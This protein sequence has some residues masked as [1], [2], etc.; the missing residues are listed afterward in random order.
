MNTPI[1]PSRLAR[2]HTAETNRV[3]RVPARDAGLAELVVITF[4]GGLLAGGAVIFWVTTSL[5]AC[6]NLVP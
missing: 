5:G 6:G 3:F 1:N 4:L 2:S